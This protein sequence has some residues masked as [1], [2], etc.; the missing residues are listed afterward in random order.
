MHVHLEFTYRDEADADCGDKGYILSSSFK[1]IPY[2]VVD[3]CVPNVVSKKNI[4]KPLCNDAL[5]RII[6]T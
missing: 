6:P 3:L 5:W 1:R 4:F 2:W